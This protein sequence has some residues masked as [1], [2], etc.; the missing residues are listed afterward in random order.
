[1]GMPQ[2][3]QDSVKAFVKQQLAELKKRKEDEA[4]Q[5]QFIYEALGSITEKYTTEAYEFNLAMDI[6]VEAS[7]KNLAE[8]F[9][10]ILEAYDP[11][12]DEARS[13]IIFAVFYCLSL[14]YKK[15]GDSRL[16]DLKALIDDTK[17][18]LLSMYPLYFEVLSR[19]YK[20]VANFEEALKNDRLAINI[21][22]KRGISNAALG[23][24]Y[25]STVCSMIK[26]R[27]PGLRPE[28]ITLAREYIEAAITYNP[29][30]PKYYFL[31]A[32]LIFL[33]A[34][35]ENRDLDA[36]LAAA[37]EA[38]TLITDEVEPDFYE[39]YQHQNIFRQ[40]S[41]A[42]YAA[43]ED[44]IREMLDRKQNPKFPCSDEALEARREKFL[45]KT[46]QDECGI[47]MLPPVPRL[48][49]N[50]KYFFICYS[51]KD[52]KSVYSD[53]L[54]LYKRK[55]PFKYDERLTHGVGWKEQVEEYI[56]DEDCL[57]VV[58]YLSKN[59]LS[60]NSVCEEI[61]IT[62]RHKRPHFCVNLEGSM[63]PSRMLIEILVEGYQKDP[64][65]FTM[66]G[67]NMML[68][69]DFFTDDAV[70]AHKFRDN[71]DVGTAHFESLVDAITTKFPE[72][73]FGE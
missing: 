16:E 52:F 9:E 40:G 67:K 62:R 72:L 71:K 44:Y 30:Y 35:Y 41:M 64:Q 57:G 13:N 38:R 51:S 37:Q 24:S 48:D 42:E 22:K 2:N 45:A 39:C 18:H 17:F 50:D 4:F 14:I 63:Y 53:L 15:E 8:C 66:D 6:F 68:F 5:I 58:F 27:D 56:S 70:F 23:S 55:I 31:K 20:R 33:T 59:I 1:M 46:K 7:Y 3:L 32:Q 61:E 10:K 28:D 43:F 19:Y 26:R 73:I 54:E 25:A 34:V 11:N 60:T 36:L 29:Q 12:A 49:K 69:L 21:L 65:N 47:E